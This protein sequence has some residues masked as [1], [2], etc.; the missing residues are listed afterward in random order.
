MDYL[1]P[2]LDAIPIMLNLNLDELRRVLTQHP[3]FEIRG[4]LQSVNGLLLTC[5][6]P[7]A[8]GDQCEILLPQ[9]RSV[10]GEVIG[11]GDGLTRVLAYEDVQDL[12]PGLPVIRK[13]SASATRVG[14]GLLGR[15]LNGLGKP[16]DD[17]G[18]LQQCRPARNKS[19]TPVPLER[20]RIQE[21]FV[22]G[23]RAIDGL[24]TLGKGQRVGIFAGSGVGK[25]TLLGELAR[26]AEADVNVIVLIG[27]RGREVRPFLEDNIG[28]SGMARSVVIVATC[29]QPPL[30]RVRACQTAITIA[31]Y[32]RRQ[33]LH[34]LFLLDSLTRLAMAQRE[35]GISQKEPPS[36][37]GY[38]PSVFKLL[39]NTVESLGNASRGSV[40]GILTVLVE[41][42]DM[43]EPI[44]DAVRSLVDGHVVLD[45]RLAE[46]GIYPAINVAQ[47]L[48]RIAG[49]VMTSEHQR[50]A[51]KARSILATYAEVEDLLRIGAYVKGTSPEID[52]AIEL[53]PH[54]LRFLNQQTGER[55]T[56]SET[57]TALQTLTDPWSF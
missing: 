29:E 51:R 17:S 11:F 57:V 43:E 53:Y 20:A 33:G 38:V 28:N 5:T 50:A 47:S 42:G 46:K 24:L 39:A 22:T 34:V 12:A 37:R 31:N 52:K 25:S 10:L 18:P 48:S 55:T 21:P 40:T 8:L 35:I 7:A 44:A 13:E 32:F 3:S 23:Q 41:G 16:I 56:F 6:L 14:E 45:R 26:G 27:E 9:G 19:T 1:A 15:V 2:W 54:L 36:T 30:M 49:D 4:K